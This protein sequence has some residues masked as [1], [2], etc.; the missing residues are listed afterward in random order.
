MCRCGVTCD[1]IYNKLMCA[2]SDGKET[3]YR[4]TVDM[5]FSEDELN[6]T[7]TQNENYTPQRSDQ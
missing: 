2:E 1:Y 3:G 6:G 5:L 7:G 4:V